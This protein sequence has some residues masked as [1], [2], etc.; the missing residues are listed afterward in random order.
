M[1]TWTSCGG[2]LGFTWTISR[3]TEAR[4]HGFVMSQIHMVWLKLHISHATVLTGKVG[5]ICSTYPMACEG[6]Y[7]K[8]VW[9]KN[10]KN[11]YISTIKEMCSVYYIHAHSQKEIRLRIYSKHHSVREIVYIRVWLYF[12][13]YNWLIGWWKVYFRWWPPSTIW[14]GHL[15]C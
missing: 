13:E 7:N 3:A 14:V 11:I 15:I 10:L 8:N 2:V 6:K 5:W 4:G 1:I 12:K 9:A